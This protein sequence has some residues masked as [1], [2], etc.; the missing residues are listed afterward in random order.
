MSLV[1]AVISGSGAA[2]GGVPE[3][4][5]QACQTGIASLQVLPRR[6]GLPA[7]WA[8]NNITQCTIPKRSVVGDPDV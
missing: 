8:V 4:A 5:P 1:D 6:V 7:L 2:N 3:A